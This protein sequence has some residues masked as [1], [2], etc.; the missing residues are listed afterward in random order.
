MKNLQDM[1][2]HHHFH[3]LMVMAYTQIHC[4]G[5]GTILPGSHY[6]PSWL[7]FT[8]LFLQHQHHQSEFGV[9]RLEFLHANAQQ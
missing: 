7:M 3:S 1:T 6:L 2:M 8:L 4:H 5:G 9:G